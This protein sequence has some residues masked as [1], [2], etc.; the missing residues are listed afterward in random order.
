MKGCLWLTDCGF[1]SAKTD[2]FYH[3]SRLKFAFLVF[4][5]LTSCS[6]FCCFC[7]LNVNDFVGNVV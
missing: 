3:L 2:S 6:L 7:L 4:V 1:Y 5:C